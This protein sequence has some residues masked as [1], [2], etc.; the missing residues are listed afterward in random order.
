MDNQVDQFNVAQFST[1]TEW[2]QALVVSPLLPPDIVG[3]GVETGEDDA[4][5]FAGID[6][7]AVALLH[8]DDDLDGV[9]GVE[10]EGGVGTGEGIV[11][12]EVFRGGFG[13]VAGAMDERSEL[14]EQLIGHELKTPLRKRRRPEP[15][16]QAGRLRL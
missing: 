15:S 5:G 4:A 3:Q 11:G 14:V 2:E 12:A 6:V 8:L 1:G 7:D 10:A 13:D 9:D 16:V